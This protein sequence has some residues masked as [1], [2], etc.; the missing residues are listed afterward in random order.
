MSLYIYNDKVISTSNV[1]GNRNAID[2]L[3]Q[4]SPFMSG[5]ILL[6]GS[7]QLT[8]HLFFLFTEKEVVFCIL[9]MNGMCQ[10]N[11]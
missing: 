10:N 7:S 5:L 11:L 9:F 6:A 4:I 8:C 2:Y 3:A 1:L